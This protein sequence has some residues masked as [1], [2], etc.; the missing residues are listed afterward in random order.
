MKFFAKN[1]NACENV[2]E[3]KYFLVRVTQLEKNDWLVY[4]K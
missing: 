1:K 4:K 2:G 3:K